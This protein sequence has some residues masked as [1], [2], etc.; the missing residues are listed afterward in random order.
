MNEDKKRYRAVAKAQIVVVID[1]DASSSEQ[2]ETMAEAWKHHSTGTS[3]FESQAG[4]VFELDWEISRVEE[5]EVLYLD[6]AQPEDSDEKSPPIKIYSKAESVR[7]WLRSQQ[8]DVGSGNDENG[9]YLQFRL[10]E[11]WSERTLGRFY[12][13]LAETWEYQCRDV[14]GCRDE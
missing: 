2:A 9:D 14:W 3:W 5:C 13:T 12:E 11:E 1:V 6:M 7:N 10:P 8:I 4:G